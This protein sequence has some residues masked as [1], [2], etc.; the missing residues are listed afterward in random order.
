MIADVAFIVDDSTSV[1][2]VGGPDAW[3]RDILGF[4]SA[5]TRPFTVSQA[6][7]RVG[8]VK[9]S[10]TAKLE[11]TFNEYTNIS[12]LLPAIRSTSY[13]G[14]GTNIADGLRTARLQLQFRPNSPK[15]AILVTDGRPTLEQENTLIE[16][17]NLKNVG[18]EI[19][20]V[21]IG[22]T[23]EEELQQIASSPDNTHNY[24]ISDLESEY[25][26]ARLDTVVHPLGT[27]LCDL[28]VNASLG[29]SS[30]TQ[31][32]NVPGS[33]V[34]TTSEN[35][36]TPTTAPTQETSVDKAHT[37]SSQAT[38]TALS[39]SFLASSGS[40]VT[41]ENLSRI[42]TVSSVDTA[43]SSSPLALSSMTA[44]PRGSS[45]VESSSNGPGSSVSTTSENPFTPTTSPTQET[46][47]DKA[48]TPSSQATLTALSA[49]FPASSG[50]FVTSENLS[51]I[52]TVSSVDT[53]TSSSPLALSSVTAAPP[54]SSAVESSS[55]RTV[56][57]SSENES[58]T[59][60]P[61]PIMVTPGM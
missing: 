1:E 58:T 28:S 29:L 22:N 23:D 39:A 37:P 6:H 61:T 9:F 49:S 20:T 21:G 19:F 38:L 57:S 54:G 3:E 42:T 11:I 5:L 60:R 56:P 47:V 46:S 17:T 34:S 48:H 26:Y 4:I 43:T 14:G 8:V 40:F 31:S 44:A 45:T 59:S 50:S 7:V 55:K 18:V 13:E 33:S 53:A 27:V 12:D 51:R 32:G 24:A 41:S 35:P 30:S 10:T 15:I 52:T 25:N 2:F 36:F 16:A